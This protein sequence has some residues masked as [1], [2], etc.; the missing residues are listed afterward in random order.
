M[1]HSVWG[2]LVTFPRRFLFNMK[3]EARA[4]VHQESETKTFQAE[5]ELESEHRGRQYLE[6]WRDTQGSAAGF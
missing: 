1:T 6:S 5:K 3:L 4:E 2:E